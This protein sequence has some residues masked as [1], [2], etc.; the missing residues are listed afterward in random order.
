M[1]ESSLLYFVAT[2]A[3][4]KGGG[5]AGELKERETPNITFAERDLQK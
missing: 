3:K 1:N 4:A 5:D 2:L